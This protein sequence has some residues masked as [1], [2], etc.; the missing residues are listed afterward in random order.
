[1]GCNDLCLL[2]ELLL[3]GSAGLPCLLAAAMPNK[4]LVSPSSTPTELE[5]DFGGEIQIGQVEGIS[6]YATIDIGGKFWA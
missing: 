4:Y 3:C 2:Q 6:S 5:F 1:M